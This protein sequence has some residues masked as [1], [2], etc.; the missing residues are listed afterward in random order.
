MSLR[1]LERPSTSRHSRTPKVIPSELAYLLYLPYKQA[2]EGPVCRWCGDRRNFEYQTGLCKT[3]LRIYT[4]DKMKRCFGCGEPSSRPLR[5]HLCQPCIG[6]K[7][8]IPENLEALI[9]ARYVGM[10]KGH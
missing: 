9:K 4:E 7:L 3:C 10:I 2:P 1:D 6:R 5:D 8:E